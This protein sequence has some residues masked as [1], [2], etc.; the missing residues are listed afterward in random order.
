VVKAVGHRYKKY[1]QRENGVEKGEG[2]SERTKF[3]ELLWKIT[4]ANNIGNLADAVRGKFEETLKRV[5]P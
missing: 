5:L 2:A 1:G 4:M 3:Q